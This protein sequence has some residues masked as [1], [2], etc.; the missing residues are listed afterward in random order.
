VNSEKVVDKTVLELSEDKK[1]SITQIFEQYYQDNSKDVDYLLKSLIPGFNPK[2]EKFNMEGVI[3]GLELEGK[4]AAWIETLFD[5]KNCLREYSLELEEHIILMAVYSGK[6]TPSDIFDFTAIY[7][8]K[9]RSEFKIKRLLIKGFLNKTEFKGVYA[10]TDKVKAVISSVVEKKIILNEYL[11]VINDISEFPVESN[12]FKL[13]WDKIEPWKEMIMVEDNYLKVLA[14]FVLGMERI[15]I[16]RV[17]NIS[18]G[19]VDDAAQRLIDLGW[20]NS[21][22]KVIGKAKKFKELIENE[23]DKKVVLK[24][25][26]Y[27][28]MSRWI[29][30]YEIMLSENTIVKNEEEFRESLFLLVKGIERSNQKIKLSDNQLKVLVGLYLGVEL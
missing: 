27:L 20:I 23:S 17:V 7:E 11:A 15:D 3:A 24:Q 22:Y 21:E 8:D 4:D 26:W 13:F 12:D 6:I 19:T 1:Q 16:A 10:L 29:D 2:V 9:K 5:N 25:L 14:G 28:G 18:D 30:E